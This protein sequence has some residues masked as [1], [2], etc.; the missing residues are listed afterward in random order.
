MNRAISGVLVATITPYD[1]RDAVMFGALKEHLSFLA[2]N[3]VD[4]V[5]PMAPTGEGFSL[6]FEEQRA[7][8]L[9]LQDAPRKLTCVPFVGGRSLRETLQLV[10][11]VEN[12]RLD[13]VMVAPPFCHLPTSDEGI[14]QMLESVMRGT[15]LPVYLLHER[16]N[17]ESPLSEGL[18][19][20]LTRSPNFAGVYA[21]GTGSQEVV[22]LQHH[23]PALNL[24][25]SSDDFPDATEFLQLHAFVTTL[26]NVYPK[27][28]ARLWQQRSSAAEVTA[29]VEKVGIAQKLFAKYPHPGAL[30]YSLMQ[31][32]FPKMCVRLPLLNLSPDQSTE[33]K[34]AF[35]LFNYK[36]DMLG[37]QLI[38]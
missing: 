1:E 15:E 34:T 2:S 35:K 19:Q 37:D 16:A 27:L 4:G 10:Y 14:A 26:G 11:E 29:L 28:F 23:F 5:I 7:V 6:T 17:A 36:H 32:G 13:A 31:M 22:A 8:L 33:F 24:W 9:A 12:C 30:K 20:R 18:L 38:A 25:C 21:R 3:G